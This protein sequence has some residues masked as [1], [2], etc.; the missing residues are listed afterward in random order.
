METKE[1]KDLT[2]EEKEIFN[3]CIKNF[4]NISQEDYIDFSLLIDEIKHNMIPKKIL[5]EFIESNYIKR[6]EEKVQNYDLF[7]KDVYD[8]L[9]FFPI[10]NKNKNK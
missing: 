9:G 1:L 6:I 2:E 7:K 4:F 3:N 10:R 5:K 8:K